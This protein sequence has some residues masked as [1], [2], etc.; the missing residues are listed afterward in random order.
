MPAMKL[1]AFEW[2]SAGGMGAE[3]PPELRTEGWLMLSALVEDFNRVRNV[4]TLTLIERSCPRRLGRVCRRLG[5]GEERAGFQEMVAQ[6]DLVMVIAPEFDQILAERS[7]WVLAAGKLLLG[8]DVA[9]IELTSDKWALAD[10]FTKLGVP[11]PLTRLL[12]DGNTEGG[13][14]FPA[15]CKPRRGAGSQA[16]FL[17]RN[18]MELLPLWREARAL[19]PSADFVLQ[20]FVPGQPAS[21]TFMM[22]PC[23]SLA[24]EPAAQK[25]SNDGRFHYL[26]GR[27]P[28]PEPL[29][30][31]AIDLGRRATGAVHGL[32]G[33]VGVDLIL[34]EAE[35]A[36]E[37][38]VIEINPRP[39]TSYIGLRRLAKDNLAE[40]LLRI[41]RGETIAP[42]R[43]REGPITFSSSGARL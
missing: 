16:T 10:H 3:T 26:G 13:V 14:S 28:L 43:W 42:I 34:G 7:R 40:A 21:V 1:F 23:Q 5:P 18:E 17:V 29:A 37:D 4:E 35:D 30:R 32:S 24:L 22:G 31:R 8:S 9:A 2:I 11:T 15:V 12:R 38:W 33:L 20:R 36:S 39:T 27:L 6:A 25:L 41:A 19:A